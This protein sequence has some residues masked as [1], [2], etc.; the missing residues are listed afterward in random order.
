VSNIDLNS[1]DEGGTEPVTFPDDDSVIGGPLHQLLCDAVRTAGL[2]AFVVAKPGSTLPA[3]ELISSR[4]MPVG[5]QG[6]AKK[7]FI[8]Q[9]IEA[10]VLLPDEDGDRPVPVITLRT[11]EAVA[12]L[13][14]ALT[15][16]QAQSREAASALRVAFRAGNVDGQVVVVDFKTV[17]LDFKDWD[18]LLG[19]VAICLLLGA[20]DVT[21]DLNLYRRRHKEKLLRRLS[22]L[23]IGALGSSVRVE[24][25]AG[26]THEPDS[27]CITLTLAQALTLADRLTQVPPRVDGL[28]PQ[29][30]EQ[31]GAAGEEGA[32]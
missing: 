31:E 28:V 6:D 12:S 5:Y 7:W 30:A 13:A 23:L 25:E 15:E 21:E 16:T 10:D 18:D 19:P 3:L 17:A 29:Q 2:S 27:V 4:G 9:G 32:P 20:D 1:L 14:S 11:A 24:F 22:L 8:D 26:C